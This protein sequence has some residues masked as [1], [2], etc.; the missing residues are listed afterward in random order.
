M[1]NVPGKG[2]GQACKLNWV[3]RCTY[4]TLGQGLRSFQKGGHCWEPWCQYSWSSVW[5]SLFLSGFISCPHLPTLTF[6]SPI[7]IRAHPLLAWSTLSLPKLFPPVGTL[8]SIFSL[9]VRFQFRCL[10]LQEALPGLLKS[11]SYASLISSHCTYSLITLLSNSHF[12]CLYPLV[13]CMICEA[14][15]QIIPSAWHI[16]L[17]MVHY[18]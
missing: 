17:H 4:L 18:P 11:I 12:A 14:C 10:F 1:E 7:L 6:S 13:D 2:W 16:S 9:S 3:P 15:S 5:F 8:F